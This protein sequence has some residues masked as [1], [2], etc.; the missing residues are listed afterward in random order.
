MSFFDRSCDLTPL[1]FFLWGYVEDK[2][3]A[4]AFQW[5]QELKEKIRAVIDEIEPQ[6]CENLMENFMKRASQVEIY[7]HPSAGP[8]QIAVVL[9]LDC[10]VWLYWV[11]G[12]RD[13]C[14]FCTVQPLAY[15]NNFC[16]TG[17]VLL[18]SWSQP[19]ASTGSIANYLYWS[20]V[21]GQ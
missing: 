4:D 18:R 7:D 6:M 14:R 1:D 5:I 3:Y 19:F 13:K 11:C 16:T 21:L 20:T 17:L 12:T 10:N 9:V 2:V 8:V 15:Y